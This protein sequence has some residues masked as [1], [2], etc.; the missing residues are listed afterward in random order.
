MAA[1]CKAAT[2]NEAPGKQSATK[3]TVSVLRFAAPLPSL[4]PPFAGKFSLFAESLM[5]CSRVAPILALGQGNS[6]GKKHL[7]QQTIAGLEAGLDPNSFV[8]IHRSYIVHLERVARIEP[9]GKDSRLAILTDGT[10]LP[11]SRAGFAR[12]KAL[13]DERK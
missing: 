5:H 7:K 13:L 12:L 8:R 1:G 4:R 2:M 9:Y 6:Q 10:R 3:C 11:V